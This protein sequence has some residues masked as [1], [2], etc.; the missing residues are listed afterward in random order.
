MDAEDV[1]AT[2]E[3]STDAAAKSPPTPAAP[4]AS[5]SSRPASAA[6]YDD[7]L[8]AGWAASQSDTSQQDNG[9][10]AEEA[11]EEKEKE[12]P[13]DKDVEDDEDED[14][15]FADFD[16]GGGEEAAGD[17]D[18]G[19]FGDFADEG[20]P[21]I[22]MPAEEKESPA[23]P[24]A[25]EPPSS[26]DWTPLVIP[27]ASTSSLTRLEDLTSQ[28]AAI[29][30][31]DISQAAR[32]LPTDPIRQA[33]GLSQVLVSER[34]RSVFADLSSQPKTLQPVD[35]LR[36][37]TR[38]D[39][40]ISLGVPINLDEILPADASSTASGS[41]LPPLTLTVDSALRS[42]AGP[43]SAP[44]T[45]R[46]SSPAAATNGN[47]RSD[48]MDALR[49]QRIMDKRKED[50][51]LGPTPEVD[52]KRVEEVCGLTEDQ[53]SL[54]PLPGLRDLARELQTLTATT[55]VLLTHHLTLRESLQADSETY[56]G[57]IKDLV[58]GA[59]NTLGKDGR[60]R[61]SVQSTASAARRMGSGS[62][63]PRPASPFSRPAAGSAG[64]AVVRR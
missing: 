60:D 31:S 64:A 53:L 7:D 37:R 42:D 14:D 18:F 12:E 52:M 35:W 24:P 22:D 25:A 30:P 21:P 27:P 61:R 59:A 46:S 13:A 28:I 39:L 33:E 3:A 1:W 48:S 43:S 56:N 17:D 34:S 16:A 54:L 55:S 41:R 32:N 4:A 23:A 57:L 29:L 63:S 44:A 50:L 15:E 62:S 38:R 9:V 20:G 26:S 2:P 36:S 8:G 6:F 58:R 40:H 45:Q 11:E 51:G 5:S 10:V 49:R 19:D 47:K